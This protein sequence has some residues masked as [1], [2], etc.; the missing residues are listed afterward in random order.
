MQPQDNASP[1]FARFDGKRYL[2]LETYRRDGRPVRTP[3]WFAGSGDALYF[4][5]DSESAKVKRLRRDSRARIAPCDMRGTVT[6][7]WM[8]AT[9]RVVDGA[10]CDGAMRRLDRKYFPWRQLLG[11]SQLF[12]RRVRAVVRLSAP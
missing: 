12:R 6:G 9:A 7:E 1:G 11:L 5:T 10:E 3:V 8:D 4:Y 2:N